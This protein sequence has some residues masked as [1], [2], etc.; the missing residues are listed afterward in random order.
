MRR[1]FLSLLLVI[2]SIHLGTGGTVLFSRSSAPVVAL[3]FDDGPNP[4]FTPHIL[5]VLEEYGVKATFFCIGEQVQANQALVQQTYKAGNE[6][7]NHSWNHPYLT[8]LPPDEIR[9]QLHSTSVAIQ[10]AIGVPPDL[11]RPPYGATDEEVRMI[12][13][14]LG[15]RETLWTIDTRDWEHPGVSAIVNT[16]LDD[17]KNESIVLMHD[18]GGNRSQTVEALP[19]I[20][21]GLEHRGFTFVVVSYTKNVRSR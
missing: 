19:Q 20:I 15:L 1:M 16:V 10:H 14:E 9:W 7:G 13:S 2:C 4:V 8:E 21:T 11:F 18:G 6:I 17:A 12:A 3:T 5:H